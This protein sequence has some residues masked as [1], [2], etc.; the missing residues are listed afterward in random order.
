VSSS[1]EFSKLEIPNDTRYAVA[2][3][4]YVV[5]I[6]KMI[7]FDDQDARSFGLGVRGAIQAAIEY[8]F[9][10]GERATLEISCERI[11]EGLKVAVKD[12]GLPFDDLMTRPQADETEAG[13]ASTLG[14]H[15]FQ[16]KKYMDEVLL[17]NLGH[18]GKEIVLIKHL[19]SQTITDYYAECELEPYEVPQPDN[20]PYQPAGKCAVRRMKSS[21]AA[22]VSKSVYK[23]YGYSYANEY[24]YYPEKII[25]LNDSGRIHSAVAVSGNSEIAGHCALQYWEENPQIAELAAGVVKP[26]FRS[27][28]CFAGMTEYLV[29]IARSERI[30]GVFGQAVTNHTYSQQ[31]G[32]QSEL[33]DC[34][35]L[36]GLVPPTV[37]FKG[38]S[39]KLY[40]RLSMVMQFRYLDGPSS[41]KL[42]IPP[43]HQRMVAG[44]YKN[45][46][47]APEIS[48]KVKIQKTDG[49]SIFKIKVI[50]PLNFARIIME[51]Y[52]E[53]AIQ[54]V[55]TKL[56]ELC[57]KKIEVIHLYLN[58]FDPLTARLTDEF[59]KLGF[60]F[61]GLLPGGLAGGDALILQYLN[62]VPIDY[63]AI[64][65]ESDLAVKI[66]THIKK[67]DPNF[68]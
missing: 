51:R 3:G 18:E 39:Q 52:G 9:E 28:G 22:E 16:L 23:T 57:L 14:I 31:T 15:V 5:E 49:N 17:H 32:H 59:E 1:C 29:N 4:N 26:E 61:T 13:T 62:N 10:P 42:Y 44:I 53:N 43:H 48:N 33:K 12:K 24:V 36:L 45:L 66:L 19:T 8:S 27:R 41:L 50:V 40:H 64:R 25:A 58:L 65:L 30:W 20:R 6:A 38:F 47:M 11:A 68:A 46:G 67:H 21:E 2:A 37:I 54:E 34:A 56:K 55:G 60:F 35:V 63:D 7:G